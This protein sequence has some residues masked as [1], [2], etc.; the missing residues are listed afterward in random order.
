M[1]VRFIVFK[2]AS[3]DHTHFLFVF[4]LHQ[5][6]HVQLM[7]KWLHGRY[8]AEFAKMCGLKSRGGGEEQKLYLYNGHNYVFEVVKLSMHECRTGC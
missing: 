7:R 6:S 3:N 5:L 2:T 4:Q 1:I 8:M